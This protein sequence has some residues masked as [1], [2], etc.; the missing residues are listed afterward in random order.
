MRKVWGLVIL[1]LV[2][3]IGY[4]FVEQTNFSV[5][6]TEENE[7]VFEK[8]SIVKEKAAPKNSSHQELPEELF[9]WIGK[10]DKE[11]LETL[12]EPDRYDMSAYDYEWWVYRDGYERYVQFGL[13][14]G[15]IETVLAT[16]DNGSF[17]PISIGESY[18]ELDEEYNFQEEIEYTEGESIFTFRMTGNDLERRPLVKLADDL[19]LQLYFDTFT[20]QLSTIR[21]YTPDILLRHRPYEIIYRGELPPEPDLN[22]DEWSLVQAGMEQQIFDISNVFRNRFNKTIFEWEQTVSDVAFLHSKDMHDNQYFSHISQN[23][24]GLIERLETTDLFYHLAGENIAAQY[25]DAPSAVE[26]WLNSEGH[27][28]ALLA[29]DYTHLG[30]GVY[31]FYY[32]QNFLAKPM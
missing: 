27:R 28:E 1:S 3:I 2:L 11:L 29:D 7:G 14:E 25:P 21:L 9:H 23:G 10:T 22:D 5:K 32:T 8:E 20:D 15:L 19:F 31:R 26:G 30:V 4:L 6:K 17:S 16:G 18:S 13:E 12:G 24:D